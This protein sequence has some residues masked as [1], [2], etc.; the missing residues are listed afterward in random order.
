MKGAIITV[1]V[2][3]FIVL[4]LT[5]FAVDNPKVSLDAQNMEIEQVVADLSKQTGL[6][7]V[8]DSDTKTAIS[9][10][11]GSIELERLLDVIT[12]SNGLKWQKFYVPSP[13]DEKLPLEKI[14]AH[15]AAVAA[16]TGG[17]IVVCDP[18]T[19]KQKVFI[20]QETSAPSIDP[21][22]LG[23]KLVY[24]ITKQKAEVEVKQ[25]EESDKEMSEQ[26]KSVQ[27]ER[28]Q[29]L[30]KMTSEQR[31]T[32]IQ[33]EMMQM[34]QLDPTVR[35]QMLIDEMRAR[36]NMDPQMREQYQQMMMETM[37]FMREQGGFGG[38]GQRGQRGGDGT[39]GTGGFGQRGQRG[40]D[41]TRGTGGQR[42]RG[43]DGTGGQRRLRTQ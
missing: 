33:Q 30:S 24:L 13:N 3:A 18:A 23:L 35:S 43:G 10:S 25:P 29:L 5:A 12:K 28:M 37:R 19:G 20:E 27:N 1:T 7:I 14:K 16:V 22:K 26:L 4:S 21:E 17:P 38:F 31:I 9:G 34:M 6:Q 8:C 36:M 40:G 39:G 42:Q 15:A 11:F 32:A 41:G 2:L